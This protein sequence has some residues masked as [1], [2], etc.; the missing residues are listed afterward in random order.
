MNKLQQLTASIEQQLGQPW[1]GVR[2]DVEIHVTTADE[3]KRPQWVLKDRLSGGFF[4]VGAEEKALFESLRE[5]QSLY[6]GIAAYVSKFN[7]PIMPQALFGFLRVLLDEGLAKSSAAKPAQQKVG[8]LAR[9][10]QILFYRLPLLKP[11]GL[12]DSVLPYTAW[13]A[14]K[15]MVMFYTL[16]ALFG[17][18]RVIPQFDLYINAA[19]FLLTAQGSTLF[20]VAIA[21]TKICHEFSHALVARAHGLHINRM[22]IL[23]MLFWPILYTDV[24]DAWRAPKHVKLKIAAAGILF[25]LALAGVALWLWSVSSDG[26]FRSLCFFISGTA[27]LTTLFINLNPL[28]RFDGYYL[29]MDYLNVP[30]LQERSGLLLRHRVRRLLWGWRESAPEQHPKAKSLIVYALAVVMYRLLLGVTISFAIYS[31]VG[32]EAG[33]LLFGF[34]LFVLVIQPWGREL[35]FVL[36]NKDQYLNKRRSAATLFVLIAV[37]ACLAI[38]YQQTT[39]HPG[40]IAWKNITEVV[41]AGDGKLT[42]ALPEVGTVVTA[43]Q[44]LSS[45]QSPELALELAQAEK[46][47]QATEIAIK[48]RDL[49]G[50]SGAV[51]RIL[52][53]ERDRQLASIDR[54]KEKQKSL[55]I[56]S[57]VTGRLIV[58]QEELRAGVDVPIGT[59]LFTVADA[60]QREVVIYIDEQSIGSAMPETDAAAMV[61]WTIFSDVDA[62]D[63]QIITVPSQQPLATQS[64]INEAHYDTSGGNVATNKVDDQRRTI[65]GY[66]R[67]TASITDVPSYIPHGFPVWVSVPGDTASLLQRFAANISRWLAAEG[68]L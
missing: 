18:V 24:T 61:E 11:D 26:I 60:E 14:S 20:I 37:T 56:R 6:A 55:A 13:L 49:G 63:R 9:Y 39:Q 48:N 7:K 10:R 3:W 47:L 53:Q 34:T 58:R 22:G 62:L 59:W 36:G 68:I 4:T 40:F 30:N 43:E 64:F 52:L 28:M 8:L 29:L 45:L 66:Y 5:H 21:I 12:L 46:H 67:L 15:P 50:E 33:L 27:L 44:R 31:F 32:A 17:L 42:A 35:L 57:P 51:R 38:P 23:F 54:L 2:Q 41:A 1:L 19:D 65:S 16:L 25:E